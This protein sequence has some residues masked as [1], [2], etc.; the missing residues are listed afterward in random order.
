ML[1]AFLLGAHMDGTVKTAAQRA[2]PPAIAASWARSKASGVDVERPPLPRRVDA[3][4]LAKRQARC[5]PLIGA[6]RPHLEWLN[7][8]FSDIRHVAYLTDGAGIVLFSLGDEEYQHA[9]GLLPG[10]DWS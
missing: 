9:F 7:A 8:Y 1:A 6:A 3:A 10:F 2:L 5:A 4:D